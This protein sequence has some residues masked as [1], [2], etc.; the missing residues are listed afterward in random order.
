MVKSLLCDSCAIVRKKGSAYELL[1]C[2]VPG[3]VQLVECS[4]WW[5]RENDLKEAALIPF[6]LY[7]DLKSNQSLDLIRVIEIF[8]QKAV[9]FVKSS[10]H[11]RR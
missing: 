2:A 9:Q 5:N 4:R 1:K 11:N 6:F 7:I 3:L 10:P 8:S